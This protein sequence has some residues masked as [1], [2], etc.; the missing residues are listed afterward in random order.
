MFCQ[1]VWASLGASVGPGVLTALT[2]E[3][4]PTMV[5]KLLAGVG[6]IDSAAIANR[7]W[8]MSR[9]VRRSP[10][11]TELFDAAA[12]DDELGG[13]GARLDASSAADAAALRVAIDSFLREHGSR[14]PNEWDMYSPSYES[15]P[16]L[17]Y[18]AIDRLR[19]NDDS[20]DPQAGEARGAAERERLTAELERTL[21]GDAETLGML[22]AALHSA[23]V[24]RCAGASTSSA[25]E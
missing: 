20:A 17:M 23:R 15:R 21:G 12:A 14:G 16:E 5:T 11:L 4:D 1:H 8:E 2:A 22:H 24:L 10:A 6:D 25:G 7:I 18:S 3:I 19:V 9:Q 13:V